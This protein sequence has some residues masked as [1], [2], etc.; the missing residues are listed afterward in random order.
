VAVLAPYAAKLRRNESAMLA[1]LLAR[2]GR[3]DEAIEVLRPATMADPECLLRMLCTMLI[4]QSRLS[5]ARVVVDTIAARGCL[6][7]FDVRM[8]WVEALLECDQIERAIADL[9]ADPDVDTAYARTRL[10]E[11]LT[12]TSEL[13]KAE[14]LLTGAKDRWDRARLAHV[15]VLKGHPE[16][17]IAAMRA[18]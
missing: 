12:A 13:D 4:G 2:H 10:A 14:A 9:R 11:L 15:L 3:V 5:E 8:E 6:D 17:A 7:P 1:D 16:E 18:A